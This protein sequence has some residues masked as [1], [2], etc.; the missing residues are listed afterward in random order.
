MRVCKYIFALF[1]TSVTSPQVLTT[2]YKVYFDYFLPAVIAQ[3]QYCQSESMIFGRHPWH[4][5]NKQVAGGR[6][7]TWSWGW[8]SAGSTRLWGWW[9]IWVLAFFSFSGELHVVDHPLAVFFLGL[10]LF[11]GFFLVPSR[12]CLLCR[13]QFSQQLCHSLLSTLLPQGFSCI[14]R[15][16][17]IPDLPTEVPVFTQLLTHTLAMDVVLGQ[18]PFG[19]WTALCQC[20]AHNNCP[21]N[22]W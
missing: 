21:A 11:P 5:A 1:S 6:R 15:V 3:K 7:C 16:S 10:T 17:I 8:H 22:T 2:T 20:R 9:P 12:F 4:H 14:S 18:V 13:P 19:S